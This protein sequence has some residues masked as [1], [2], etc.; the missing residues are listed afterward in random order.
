MGIDEKEEEEG[1]EVGDGDSEEEGEEEEEEGEAVEEKEEE[2]GNKLIRL[3]PFYP[4]RIWAQADRNQ[5]LLYGCKLAD[6]QVSF[7]R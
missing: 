2:D 5:K 1:V 7:R 6:A 4:R 3:E